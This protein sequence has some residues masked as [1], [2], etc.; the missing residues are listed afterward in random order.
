[1]DTTNLNDG[2]NV[3]VFYE[4]N[5]GNGSYRRIKGNAITITKD[6]QVLANRTLSDY[7]IERGYYHISMAEN[8]YTREGFVIIDGKS[9]LMFK[10]YGNHSMYLHCK[11]MANFIRD[12][13]GHGWNYFR[14]ILSENVSQVENALTFKILSIEKY[15]D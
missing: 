3:M 9:G 12:K 15:K 13:F 5:K 1:M 6:G 11:E 7:M 10:D 14:I 4:F 8:V 2:Q